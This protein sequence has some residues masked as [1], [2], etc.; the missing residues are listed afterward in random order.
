MKEDG[1][2]NKII[3][4]KNEFIKVKKEKEIK[5]NEQNLLEVPVLQIIDM[6]KNDSRH[7][8]APNKN[9]KKPKKNY[10]HLKITAKNKEMKDVSSSNAINNRQNNNAIL[11]YKKMLGRSLPKKYNYNNISNN[12][13]IDI[14]NYNSN[15][16][17]R[18]TSSNNLVI[19]NNSGEVDNFQKIK[20]INPKN[21]IPD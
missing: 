11:L 15:N 20:Y 17:K 8:T 13:I 6:A 4:N 14:Q 12:I 16:I 21:N 18:I 5:K 1:T 10:K 9:G 2:L 7:I 19:I 3:I